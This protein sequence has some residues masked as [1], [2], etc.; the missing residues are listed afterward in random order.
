MARI[1]AVANQKGGCGKSTI[2]I[3]VACAL[4]RSASVTLIDADEQA[5][6]SHY[7]A[8]GHLPI[9]LKRLPLENA[10]R[11]GSWSNQVMGIET[12]YVVLDAPAHV[13]D[14]TRA[15][16]GLSDLVLIP[17]SPSKADLLATV[18]AVEL[19]REARRQRSRNDQGPA[20]LLLPSRVDTRTTSGREIAG[21]L[22]K[23]GEPVGPAVHSRAAFVDAMTAGQWIG[24]YAPNSPGHSDINAVSDAVAK[25]WG[26]LA[27]AKTTRYR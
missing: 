4:A 21:A 15:V 22:E 17:C 27:K 18:A 26:N 5:T 23:L 13:G 6:A 20:C 12:D 11:A 2:A 14:I 25:H 7:G 10:A 9:K 3:N 16:V 1:V 8:D 19:V 24:E